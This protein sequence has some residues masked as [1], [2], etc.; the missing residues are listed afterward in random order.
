MKPLH[1]YR[2]FCDQVLK[3]SMYDKAALFINWLGVSEHGLLPSKITFKNIPFVI[4]RKT[5]NGYEPG[6]SA[7]HVIIQ[8]LRR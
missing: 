2:P 6:F 4:L 8:T 7:K 3:K 5:K 1:L